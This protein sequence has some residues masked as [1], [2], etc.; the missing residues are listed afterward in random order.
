MNILFTICARAGSKGIKGKNLIKIKKKPLIMHTYQL[1]KNI[2]IKKDIVVST[3]SKLIQKLVKKEHSWFIRSKKLSGDKIS[4]IKVI[5]DAVKKAEKKNMKTYDIIID[6][7]VTSPLRN[8]M[9]VLKS[10][11][12]FKIKN[13]GNLFT[14][15]NASKNPYFNMIE[16]KKKKVELVKRN[17]NFHSRQAAPKVY[18]MN[19]SIYIWKRKVLFS[20]KP[21]YNN[22]TGIFIM[23]KKRSFDI[24]DKVDLKIVKCLIN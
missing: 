1:V 17:S 5:M 23:P 8:K 15:T 2:K 20:K 21:L 9:D 14:V 12:K 16:I 24:D 19:A 11:S 18:S 10:F 22:S 6:L 13:Y 3:D 4:K 7:D